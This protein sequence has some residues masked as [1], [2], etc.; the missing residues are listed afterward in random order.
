MS[1][2]IVSWNISGGDAPWHC[3]HSMDAD[4]ALLQE[5][6]A[7]PQCVADNLEVDPAPWCTAGWPSWKRRTAIAKLSDRVKVEWISRKSFADANSG[8]LA[9]S[10]LGTLTAA[11]VTVPGVEPLVVV[12][13]YSQWE[14]PHASTCSKWI[15]SDASAHRLVSDLSAFIGKI[16]GHRIVAAG[17]LNILYGHGENGSKY[18]AGRYA[19]VF[20]RMEA[21][22][23]PFVGPQ[24]PNGRQADPWPDELPPESK[25][26]PTFHSVKQTP[27]SAARQLDFV[28]ASKGLANR[29]TARALNEPEEWGPSDHC[30][31]VIEVS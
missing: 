4:I 1:V 23:L 30:R 27:A 13:M 5:A 21:L 22:G 10:R 2:R 7:P 8:E 9:V 20:D 16:V 14:R 6:A 19:T 11:H 18:W 15:V 3:L 29:V 24:Y 31:L 25:N 12:S 17:D 26:V 28:F